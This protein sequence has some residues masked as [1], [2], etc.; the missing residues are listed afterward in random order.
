MSGS[1]QRIL[2]EIKRRG[3][4]SVAELSRALGRTTV[5]VRH[6]LAALQEAGLVGEPVPRPRLGPGRPEQAYDLTSRAHERLPDNLAELCEY[7]LGVID[8]ALPRAEFDATLRN[9]GRRLGLE[10]RLPSSARLEDRLR[11]AAGLFEARGYLPTMHAGDPARLS[12]A[13]CPYRNLAQIHPAL[14]LFDQSLLE[15][16]LGVPCSLAGRIADRRPACVFQLTA[17]AVNG[18]L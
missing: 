5:T 8:C 6:H 4:Q 7:L 3:P 15:A 9:A 12:L 1:Q 16:L 11:H 14:C 10:A 2:E 18:Q 13:H 17:P